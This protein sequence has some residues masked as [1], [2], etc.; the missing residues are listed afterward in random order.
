MSRKSKLLF[1]QMRLSYAALITFVAFIVATGSAHAF[2]QASDITQLPVTDICKSA[3]REGYKRLYEYLK[4]ENNAQLSLAWWPDPELTISENELVDANENI[5]HFRNLLNSA[6]TQ[7]AAPWIM[8]NTEHKLKRNYPSLSHFVVS[9]AV[10]AVREAPQWIK[11]LDAALAVNKNVQLDG[12]IDARRHTLWAAFMSRYLGPSIALCALSLH[13]VDN[14][15]SMYEGIFQLQSEAQKNGT[16]MDYFN[17]AAG[18]L[19]GSTFVG[20][21]DELIKHVENLL[22]TGKLAALNSNNIITTTKAYTEEAT[23]IRNAKYKKH[24]L[25]MYILEKS[26]IPLQQLPLE[27]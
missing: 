17:N 5:I 2:G 15:W 4:Y 16:I 11:N 6:L 26:P 9:Q 21:D 20:S 25:K 10:R 1:S 22:V 8:R 13:E 18:V 19:L 3:H 27:K 14:T 12:L 7:L 23:A 24:P